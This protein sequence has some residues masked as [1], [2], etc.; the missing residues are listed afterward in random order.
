MRTDSFT[1]IA[2]ASVAEFLSAQLLA[3]W[4][5]SVVAKSLNPETVPNAAKT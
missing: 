4:S 5:A 1:G 2:P 3:G